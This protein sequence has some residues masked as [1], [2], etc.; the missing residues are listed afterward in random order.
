[1]NPHPL[2]AE[3]SC[4]RNFPTSANPIGSELV[5]DA[6]CDRVKLGLNFS[7]Y[8]E[9]AWR[10]REVERVRFFTQI[11]MGIFNAHDDVI[12]KG[13]LKAKASFPADM[14]FATR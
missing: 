3:Q 7:G 13:V 8:S 2:F 4:R 11:K 6:Q 5:A 10:R 12:C 1:M 14:C 9:Q